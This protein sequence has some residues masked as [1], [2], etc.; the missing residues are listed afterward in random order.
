MC[1]LNRLVQGDSGSLLVYGSTVTL[2]PSLA[3]VYDGA[4]REL[5]DHP[6]STL[7]A[8]SDRLKARLESLL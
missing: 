8:W 2:R 4:R 6:G 1:L 7:A 3:L 5:E